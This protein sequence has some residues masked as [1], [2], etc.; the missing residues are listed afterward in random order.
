MLT[1][2]Y[3]VYFSSENK[4]P[5][6]R[7]PTLEWPP[8]NYNESYPRRKGVKGRR[9]RTRQT[10]MI[11]H[12]FREFP[13]RPWLGFSLRRREFRDQFDDYHAALA[14][15]LDGCVNLEEVHVTVGIGV[16][17]ERLDCWGTI[18]RDV[19]TLRLSRMPIETLRLSLPSAHHIRLL[20]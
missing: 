6:S 3:T 4:Y 1:I 5:W 9:D 8:R 12:P 19:L 14:K 7:G 13:T 18:L 20:F 10:F 15:L 11:H 17:T 2:A 16:E